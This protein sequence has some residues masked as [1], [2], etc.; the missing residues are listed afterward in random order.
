MCICHYMHILAFLEHRLYASIILDPLGEPFH[1]FPAILTTALWQKYYSLQLTKEYLGS[2]RSIVP[3]ATTQIQIE[4]RS[5][6]PQV[7]HS[8]SEI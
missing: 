5:T 4:Y 7:H 1:I 2:E 3:K 8:S 6:S